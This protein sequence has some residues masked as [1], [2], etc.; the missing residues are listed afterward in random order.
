MPAKQKAADKMVMTPYFRSEDIQGWS[1]DV[2]HSV[3]VHMKHSGEQIFAACD[4]RPPHLDILN[5]G[6]KPAW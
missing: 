1:R 3:L 2:Y 4:D 6:L 5:I